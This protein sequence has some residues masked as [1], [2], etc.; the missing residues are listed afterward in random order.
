MK[1]TSTWLL[2]ASTLLV[3]LGCKTTPPEP[4]VKTEVIQME[5]TVAAIDQ[6]TRMVLL[7]GPAGFSSVEAGPEV[8]NLDRVSVGDKV[9]VSYVA[10]IAA[11]LNKSKAVSGAPQDS[12]ATYVAPAG[13]RPAAGVGQIVQTTVTIESVDTSFNTVTFKRPDGFVRVL[14]VQSDEARAFIRTL[15]AGDKVDVTYTE[16]VAVAVVPGK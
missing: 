9:Q 16:A 2:A 6:A 14:A 10:G 12:T 15:R 3:M 5:A 8:R 4:F 7:R 13:A 11:Q 1:K